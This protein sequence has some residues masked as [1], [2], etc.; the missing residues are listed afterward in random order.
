MRHPDRRW[1]TGAAIAIMMIA[2]APYLLLACGPS[3]RGKALRASLVGVDASRDGFLAYDQEAQAK[4]VADATSLEEGR[5]A[6]DTYRAERQKVVAAFE[7]AYRMIALALVD[8]ADLPAV[9]EA[10]ASL[11][12]AIDSLRQLHGG[13][14]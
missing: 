2:F 14:P 12:D 4:I 8:K 3:S 11:Q 5:A 7:V 9:V 10:A 1:R 6:L 13:T